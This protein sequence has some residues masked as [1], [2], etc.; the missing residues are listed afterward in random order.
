MVAVRCGRLLN[1]NLKVGENERDGG[2]LCGIAKI[3]NIT[4]EIPNITENNLKT[5][6]RY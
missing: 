4:A 6:A 1:P 5:P 2:S 3:L